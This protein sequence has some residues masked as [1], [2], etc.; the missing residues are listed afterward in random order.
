MLVFFLPQQACLRLD[1]ER[2]VSSEIQFDYHYIIIITAIAITIITTKKIT[3]RTKVV[4]IRG[5]LIFSAN[6]SKTDQ[7]HPFTSS[8]DSL[9]YLIWSIL[10]G[11]HQKLFSR[12]ENC[13]EDLDKLLAALGGQPWGNV[14]QASARRRSEVTFF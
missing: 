11:L 3:S 10:L 1:V 5:G 7:F 13:G 9:G 14:A 6:N 4:R 2:P 8:P 12:R